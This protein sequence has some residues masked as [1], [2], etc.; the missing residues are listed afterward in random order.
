MRAVPEN[1]TDV[2]LVLDHA[3]FVRVGIDQSHLMA[4]GRQG[5]CQIATDLPCPHHR[6]ALGIHRLHTL[7]ANGNIGTA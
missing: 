1:E 4:L 5:P 2:E 6:V 3:L 7:L